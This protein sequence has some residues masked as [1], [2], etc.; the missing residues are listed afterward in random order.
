MQPPEELHP[1]STS[2]ASRNATR[3]WMVTAIV[4]AVTG[5]LCLGLWF[6]LN[7]RA[8]KESNKV[9]EKTDALDIDRKAAGI[10]LAT[11]TR[12]TPT[13]T[14]SVAGTVEPNQQQLQQV[15]P[16]VSGRVQRI[17]VSL[18]DTVKP[19]TVLI[20]IDSPQ[21]AEMHGKLHEAETRLRLSKINLDRVQQS[22]NRVSVLKSKASLDEAESNLKRTKLLVSEGLTARK[23]LVATESEYDRA[24][25][26][27][28]FQKDIT[29]NREVT[30][31]KAEVQT[32]ETET[33]H[34][35]DALRALDAH[36]GSET[37]VE[38]NISQIELRSPIAGTIIERFVNPGSGFEQGKP[39]LTIANTNILWVIANV[40]E[41]QMTGIHIG[42]PANVK[43]GNRLVT[44]A[45]SYIDP[46]LNEDTRTSRVRIEIANPAHKIQV[47]S[48]AQVE[49]TTQ[50]TMQNVP[51]V[52][53]AAVQTVDGKPVVFVKDRTSEQFRVRNVQIG[54]ATSGVV[55]ILSGLEVGEQVAADGSFVLKSKLLKEQFGEE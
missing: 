40:P 19:G 44:G 41:T 54:T 7:N 29:L 47:G 13:E 1:S 15:T 50:A 23:D 25:A 5:V 21:V 20:E 9:E 22:A 36:L 33:E 53:Q 8:P 17:F 12:Q 18:G 37:G 38:H 31:A 51:F 6:V 43:L 45:V 30:Q 10:K 32:A 34:I 14:F 2:N 11:V 16:L 28:N 49:F 4:I 26:E 42:S 52:P 35:R 46:R 55:P 24:K 39:L 3:A 27:Y 48:F